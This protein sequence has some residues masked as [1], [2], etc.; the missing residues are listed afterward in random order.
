V[1]KTCF[2]PKNINAF[3][4]ER[5]RL[6]SSLKYRSSLK[7]ILAPAIV[8]FIKVIQIIY[9]NLALSKGGQFYLLPSKTQRL[10]V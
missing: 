7:I 8:P 2:D 1:T 9:F 4:S 5:I 3:R 6:T 10:A